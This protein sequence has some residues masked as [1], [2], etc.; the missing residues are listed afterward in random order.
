ME[1]KSW[2]CLAGMG[3]VL[4]PVLFLACGGGGGSSSPA[5]PTG[6]VN[7]SVRDAS[8]E[9]WATVGVK[10]LAVYLNPKGGGAPVQVYAAPSPAPVT[11]LVALDNLS[12]ILGMPGNVPAGTYDGATLVLAANPGDVSLV[13]AADPQAGFAGS[14]GTA[15]AAGRVQVQH[16]S[17][18]AGN[19]T[20]TVPVTFQS[21]LVVAAGQAVPVDV[22]FDLAHPAF[23]VDHV[24]AG[25]AAYWAVNFRGPVRHHPVPRLARLVLRHQYGTVSAVATGGTSFTMTKAYP[26]YPATSPETAVATTV[27]LAIQ[28]DAANGT[29]YYDVDAKADGVVLHDFATLAASLPGKFVRVAARY[30]QDGSLVAVRVWAASTFNAIWLSP[31]GHVLHVDTRDPA[32]PVVVIENENG[33]GVPVTVT[34]AT[35]IFFRAPADPAADAQPITADPVAFVNNKNL[36]R[37]FKVHASVTDPLAATLA[38]QTLDIE[39]A[40]YDGWISAPTSTG[41]TYTRAYRTAL[42]RYTKTLPYIAAASA[43]GADA[44]GNPVAGFQWWNFAFPTL[45][46]TGAAAIPDFIAATGGSVNFYSDPTLALKPW[47]ISFCRWDDPAA[48]GAWAANEAVL[49]PVPVPLGSVASAWTAGGAGGSFGLAVPGGANTVA[50]DVNASAQSA[51]LA[52][53]VDLSGAVLTVSPEDLTT[54]A[55][56]AATAAALGTPGTSV[57]VYGIPQPDG[58]LKAYVV[59]YYTGTA[60][61]AAS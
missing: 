49:L 61:S 7:L 56:L 16:A 53:Q 41:F 3:A 57:K 9:D 14:P 34:S 21:D 38:A 25:G 28:A 45:A 44:T 31:E 24:P 29:L 5:V 22:E 52:Y 30:Q 6:Q 1:A 13:A 11:N 35:R 17:G 43:N 27:P 12:E 46:D 37:G 32:A 19:R 2:R 47:G 4:A 60:P 23:I 18:P 39:I 42:D 50:V 33:A 58:H 48:A 10:I 51:T 15:V 54:S 59:L 40:K 20:V 36:V 55:G 8:T 26:V